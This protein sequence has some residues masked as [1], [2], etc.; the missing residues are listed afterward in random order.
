MRT[1]NTYDQFNIKKNGVNSPQYPIQAQPQYDSF[2]LSTDRYDYEESMNTKDFVTGAIF[3]AVVGAAA[4]LMF[5]PKSGTELRSSL[6]SQAGSLKERAS[7]LTD[8][9]KDKTSSLTSAVQEKSSTLM[10]KVKSMKSSDN[11]D[12][13]TGTMNSASLDEKKEDAK[14]VVDSVAEAVKDTVDTTADT[15]KTKLD[16]TKKAFDEAEK[17]KN[18]SNQT[19]SNTSS[20]TSTSTA[21]VSSTTASTNATSAGW[22]EPADKGINE[23]KKNGGLNNNNNNNNG[24]RNNNSNKK[25]NNK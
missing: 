8:T 24:N 23:K 16:E 7:G 5:A 11:A 3:G 21:T 15:A 12:S 4:A 18:N 13:G 2:D 9:A 10:D 22:V 19:S 25:F 1:K 20:N 6:N 17:A 14:S